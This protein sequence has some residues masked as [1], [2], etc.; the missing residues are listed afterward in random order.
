MIYSLI[1]DGLQNRWFKN[2]AYSAHVGA[3]GNE[4]IAL[5]LQT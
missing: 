2:Y 5:R 1:K 4:N 3:Q